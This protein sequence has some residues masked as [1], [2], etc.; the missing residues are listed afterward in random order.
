MLTEVRYLNQKHNSIPVA[1]VRTFVIPFNY[2]SGS[3]FL[4]S[5]NYGSAREKVAVPPTVPGPV[6]QHC[7]EETMSKIV[8]LLLIKILPKQKITY[9]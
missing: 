8:S 9:K 4:K 7:Q 6:S 1:S 5:Y 3:D 2:G